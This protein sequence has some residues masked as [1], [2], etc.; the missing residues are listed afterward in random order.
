M[1]RA[2]N[3]V[4]PC[5]QRAQRLGRFVALGGPQTR[6][7]HARQRRDPHRIVFGRP[8]SLTK[9]APILCFFPS[10]PGQRVPLL[11]IDCRCG[12]VWCG[13]IHTL[14]PVLLML[15]SS[16]VIGVAVVPRS[17]SELACLGG[18]DSSHSMQMQTAALASIRPR[19]RSNHNVDTMEQ[20]LLALKSRFASDELT[21][22]AT[23]GMTCLLYTSP[24]PRDR[25]RSR[26]P[27]SA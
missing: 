11:N 20:K 23:N 25:T 22:I 4:S 16:D 12:V 14:V 19:W 15:K 2:T 27:S 9:K 26:M 5:A 6:P 3:R 17:P 8:S 21:E 24:S 10:D 18:L 13:V 1:A 7:Q